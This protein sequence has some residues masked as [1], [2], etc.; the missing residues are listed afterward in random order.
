MGLQ[1]YVIKRILVTIILIWAIATVNF[2]IFNML[3]G[4]TIS[5]YVAKLASGGMGS[6]RIEQLRHA[7]GLDRPIHERYLVYLKNMVTFNFGY[8]HEFGDVKAAIMRALPNTLI[9]MGISEIASIIIGILL[10]VITAYKRGTILDSGIVTGSLL[11]YSVPVFWLGWIIVNIFAL[12]LKWFPSGGYIPGVWA[13]NPPENIITL[14]WGRLWCTVLPAFTLF[15]FLVGGWILLTRASVL[16]TITEDY[17]VTARAKGLKT[18]T[19]LYKHVLK[20][21][22]LPLITNIAMTMGFLI[23]GA[24][25]TET[26]FSYGGMG[27]LIF[28]AIS[29]SDIPMIQAVFF[30]IAILVVTANFIADLL[31]GIIDPRIRYG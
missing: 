25:I 8:S 11:T 10:G 1:E 13:V 3:P 30:V 19:I 15:I 31:Y 28:T 23:T 12:H 5:K 21:A 24:V 18:R 17:V 6:E 27:S 26:V 14:I 9:L 2:L 7:F 29:F 20:N 16:E 4:T 22:S